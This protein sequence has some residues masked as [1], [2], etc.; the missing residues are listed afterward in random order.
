MVEKEN[1]FT[2]LIAS[3]DGKNPYQYLIGLGKQAQS[4]GVIK[5]IFLHKDEMNAGQGQWQ[6]YVKKI[7]INMLTNLSLNAESVPLLAG[8]LLLAEI[9]PTAHIIFSPGCT[10]FDNA[11]FDINGYRELGMRYGAEMP[12]VWAFVD[13]GVSK[14]KIK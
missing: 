4:D 2:P 11:H 14:Q 12:G 1:W 3:Y 8:E 7:D 5:G 9:I 10:G 13:G 6:S